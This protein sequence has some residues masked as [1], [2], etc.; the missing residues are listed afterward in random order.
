MDFDR[1]EKFPKS[2]EF[3]YSSQSSV[4]KLYFF[5]RIRFF[6]AMELVSAAQADEKNANS[7]KLET[8]DSLK[9]HSQDN[10]HVSNVKN[11]KTVIA[12]PS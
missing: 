7:L 6:D 9:N 3:N 5:T 1:V 8:N 11:M 10:M 2:E 4:D 12:S